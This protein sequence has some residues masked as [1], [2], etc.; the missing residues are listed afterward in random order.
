MTRRLLATAALAAALALPTAATAVVP[1]KN[2]GTMTAKGKS[3]Q[4]K[5]DQISCNSGRKHARNF[6]EKG[7]RPSG[8]T[9]KDYPSRKGSVDFYCNDG[10]KIFLAIRR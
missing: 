8:Y 5:A 1:P 2:C 6:L 3:Y 10:K 7:R 9:C 4:V